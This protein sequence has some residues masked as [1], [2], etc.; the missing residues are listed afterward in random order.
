VKRFYPYLEYIRRIIAF[1]KLFYFILQ[2]TYNPRMS[3][4]R[5][6]SR[7]IDEYKAMIWE[8]ING[9]DQDVQLK[10]VQITYSEASEKSMALLEDDSPIHPKQDEQLEEHFR[11]IMLACVIIE[12]KLTDIIDSA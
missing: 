2:K 6:V 4:F 9:K 10:A 3:E 1:L 5:K 8:A 11:L 12:G 7:G